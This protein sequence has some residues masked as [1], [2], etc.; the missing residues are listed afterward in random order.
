MDMELG[1]RFGT[2]SERFQSLDALLSLASSFSLFLVLFLSSPVVA[3]SFFLLYSEPGRI[4]LIK[5]VLQA[6]PIYQLSFSCVPKSVVRNLNSIFVKFLWGGGGGN[7]GSIAWIKWGVLCSNKSEGGLG[8]K[9]LEW[10]SWASVSKW[11]WRYLEGEEALWVRVL[12]SVHG[13]VVWGGEGGAGLGCPGVG[14]GWWPKILNLGG[15]ASGGWFLQNLS[16]SIGNGR[17]TKF[18]G[19]RWLGAKPLRYVDPRLFRLCVDRDVSVEK[20]GN[21]V[22]GTWLWEFRWRRQLFGVGERIA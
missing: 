5:A 22:E 15:R 1:Y 17:N 16:R 9:N 4:T 3:T 11:I 7:S 18:W 19:N 14:R 6:I 13:D 20:F 12:R 8:F 2:R 10:F 21:W